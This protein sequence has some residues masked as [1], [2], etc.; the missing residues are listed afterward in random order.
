MSLGV[1]EVVEIL[2]SRSGLAGISGGSGDMRDLQE[3]A[4]GGDSRARLALDV[5]VRSIRHYLGAFF[6]ELGG[7]DVLTF[8]GGIGEN[9]PEIRAAVCADW[10]AWD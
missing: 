10:E 1:D 4:A 3:A 8:S 2:S 9:S 7:L 6:V 5:L